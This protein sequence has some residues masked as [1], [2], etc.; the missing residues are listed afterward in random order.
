MATE[1]EI[2]TTCES[3]ADTIEA[4]I[5]TQRGGRFLFTQDDS[6]ALLNMIETWC[7]DRRNGIEIEIEIANG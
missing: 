6:V 5:S 2:D 4:T 7:R 1:T 3:L